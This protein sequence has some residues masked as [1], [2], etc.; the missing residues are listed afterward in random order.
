MTAKS[1]DALRADPANRNLNHME[2]CD[3]SEDIPSNPTAGPSMGEVIGARYGRRSVLKGALATTAIA[4]V[5]GPTALTASRTARAAAQSSFGFT[6]IAHGVD[7]RHHVAPGYRADVLIRWGDPVEAGAPAFDPQRQSA[8]AQ[9]RQFGYNC[10]YVGFAALPQGGSAADHGLLFVNHEYTNEELMF[11]GLGGRQ[12]T[13]DMAFKSMT[14]D[15]VD[16]EL[17]AHG[18]SIIEV[19]RGADGR[20]SYDPASRYNRRITGETEIAISGPAAGH[21]RMKTAADPAGRKARGMLNNC[22]GGM[23]PWG[24]FL[25]GEENFH[26][27]FWGQLPDG[28]PEAANHKRYGV[29]GRWYN[30]G[31]FHDRFDVA[32]EPNEANRFGWI[33]EVDPYDPQSLP[34]KRTALGRMKH[35]G[36]E[37]ILNRDGR[38][39]VYTGDDER[40]EYV[41]KFVSAGRFNPNDRA[42]NRNL[43]DDGTL[44]VARYDADGSGAW[45]PLVFGQGPLTEAN[46]FRSQAD[47]LIEARRAADLLGATKM[48]RPED[49]EANRQTHKVYAIM[50]NNTRRGPDQVDAANP[51]AK[52]E[53]GHIIEMTEAGDDHAATSFRWEILIMA[54]DPAIADI[55]AKYHP[56]TSKDGWFACPDNCA[57]DAAGRLWV[58]TDQGSSWKRASS[59]ADGLYAVE[60]AGALRGYSRMFF[61][62]PVGAELCGPHF[63]GDGRTLFLAVQHPSADGT[64]DWAPFGRNATFEDPATRWPDFQPNMPPRP[65]V[66]V[67]T[68]EGGGPIGT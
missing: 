56:A 64:K 16:I 38:V 7:E 25:S 28:Q 42:A 59:T 9:A 62:V 65:S 12:D 10:D 40:F 52:N 66:V 51:R 41:Y 5:L 31:A 34:V 1:L 30:W 55:A 8:A 46:G 21:D 24:T 29:P 13:K 39:V 6:E 49:V 43:L 50:T 58:A 54:G 68:K 36:A 35:E 4:A 60:A 20:W 32:K 19:R 61:R 17:A 22:A 67:V 57:V 37:T 45:R 47:V 18:A 48:D 63:T 11:P 27:Y 33:V 15:L 14:R 23:T 2:L 3:R 53:W 44:Y 26:G